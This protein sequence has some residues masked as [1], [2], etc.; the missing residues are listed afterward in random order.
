MAIWD[1]SLM[2]YYRLE[3]GNGGAGVTRVDAAN[4]LVM[5]ECHTSVFTLNA[6]GKIDAALTF[7][8]WS[9]LK[10][11][12]AGLDHTAT[13]SL[14]ISLWAYPVDFS[15]YNVLTHQLNQSSRKVYLLTLPTTGQLVN[16]DHFNSGVNLTLNA[17][18]H[19]VWTYAS[20]GTNTGTEIF[21][22]NGAQVATRTGAVPAPVTGAFII[23]ND[24]VDGNN[25][26]FAGRIDEF[27]ITRRVWTPTEVSQ[28][29][30][31]SAGLAYPNEPAVTQSQAPR[32]MHQYR[33]RRAA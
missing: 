11:T 14:S 1:A 21:Y 18:Q 13:D 33:V 30:N 9:G 24:K 4:G 10:Y 15:G 27:A 32:S 17:W 12:G 31:A 22:I 16:Y 5:S 23:G 26:A 19:I 6:V 8:E 25:N 2:A 20:G 3:G 7:Q 29:Y 28:I